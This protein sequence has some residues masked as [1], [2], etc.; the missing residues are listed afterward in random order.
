MV[1]DHTSVVRSATLL[2][3]RLLAGILTRP[4]VA[5]M[6]RINEEERGVEARTVQATAFASSIL[7]AAAAAAG[8]A[9]YPSATVGIDGEENYI[10]PSL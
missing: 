4:A 6:V 3:T 7:R 8:A 2:L 5:G 1:F 9:A 10:F